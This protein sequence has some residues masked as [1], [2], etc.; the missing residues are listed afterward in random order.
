[1]PCKHKQVFDQA[2]HYLRI[3]SKTAEAAAP[4]FDSGAQFAPACSGEKA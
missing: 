4:L 1:M 3:S 2:Q